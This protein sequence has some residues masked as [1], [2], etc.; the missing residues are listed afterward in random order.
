[1][2]LRF[3]TYPE[4]IVLTQTGRI[5]RILDALGCNDLPGVDTPGIDTLRNDKHD[6]DPA[7][8]TF[9]YDSVIGRLRY[10]CAHSSRPDLSSAVSQAAR[11]ASRPKRSHER[12]VPGQD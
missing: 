1:M 11:F 8:C 7:I 4:I 5:D 10:L 9:N 12:P 2:A 3:Q 6:G